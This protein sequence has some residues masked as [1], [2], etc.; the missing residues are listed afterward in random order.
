MMNRLALIVLC[1]VTASLAAQ[2]AGPVFEVASIK[3]SAAVGDGTFSGS[4]VG[5]RPGGA[6]TAS[7]NSV[8]QLIRFAY[9]FLDDQI[10]GGPDWIRSDRINVTAKAPTD[11]P[12]EQVRHML[13]T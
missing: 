7:N 6:F 12:R 3:P 5:V 2:P 4:G 1:G 9:N 8:L 10:I 13:R 11:V